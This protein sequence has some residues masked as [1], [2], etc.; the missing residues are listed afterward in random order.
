MNEIK[1]DAEADLSVRQENSL[2]KSL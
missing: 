2:K 1:A